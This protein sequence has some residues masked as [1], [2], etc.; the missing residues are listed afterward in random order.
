MAADQQDD[1]EI[2]RLLVSALCSSSGVCKTVVVV[3]LICLTIPIH[4]SLVQSRTRQP[5][6]Q[7]T[8]QLPQAGGKRRQC[9]RPPTSTPTQ[10]PP[11]FCPSACLLVQAA[12]NPD[13]YY[14]YDYGERDDGGNAG[15]PDYGGG[16]GK[17]RLAAAAAGAGVKGA[18]A[19]GSG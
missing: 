7:F 16:N 19:A 4:S 1:A 8:H 14:E 15:D 10:L 9:R 13:Q 12:E 11:I 3:W 2:A 5:D 18:L 17:G 6:A